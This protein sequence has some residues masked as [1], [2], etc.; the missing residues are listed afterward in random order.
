MNVTFSA[1][2]FKRF[3]ADQPYIPFIYT[4]CKEHIHIY[5]Q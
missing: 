3:N 1:S 2:F 5:S 4:E